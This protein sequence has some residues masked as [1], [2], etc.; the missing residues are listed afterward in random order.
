MISKNKNPSVSMSKI[1]IDLNESAFASCH[2]LFAL[3]LYVAKKYNF[4]TSSV[5]RTL[6]KLKEETDVESLVKKID[7]EI[8]NYVVFYYGNGDNDPADMVNNDILHQS[9]SVKKKTRKTQTRKKKTSMES[10][11]DNLVEAVEE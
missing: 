6:L 2:R 4:K 3:Y 5:N 7:N 10:L 9:V 8:G 11:E 1:G